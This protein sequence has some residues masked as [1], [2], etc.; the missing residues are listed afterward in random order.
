MV[1]KRFVCKYPQYSFCGA[2]DCRLSQYCSLFP[3]YYL[4][5]YEK[6]YHNPIK[7]TPEERKQHN[8]NLYCTT[9]YFQII[10]KKIQ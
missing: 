7:K 4:K 2:F 5:S 10:K 1:D 3:I 9:L 6:G 8:Q